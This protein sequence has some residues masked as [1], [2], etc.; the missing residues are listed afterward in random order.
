MV[1]Y[2]ITTVG[3]LR[4]GYVSLTW[5]TTGAFQ[6]GAG[7][8]AAGSF[9]AL[10]CSLTILESSQFCY[11]DTVLAV[12]LGQPILVDM[13][14]TAF[15]SGIHSGGGGAMGIT[16][17]FFTYQGIPGASPRVP[18]V[19]SVAAVPEPVYAGLIA[20]SLLAML[21]SRRRGGGIVQSR[22]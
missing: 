22:V 16:A 19:V 2:V 3:P 10:N 9:G 7:A 18:V 21:L 13:S 12:T 11:H 6:G 1:P 8:S 17:E 14:L 20:G 5:G 15:S 4:T